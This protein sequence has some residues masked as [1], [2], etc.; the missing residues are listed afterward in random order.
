MDY[1]FS[2]GMLGGYLL[3]YDFTNTAPPQTRL[4]T[5]KWNPASVTPNSKGDHIARIDAH[6][7]H[8]FQTL[9]N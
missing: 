6:K 4:S 2:W 5:L 8:R 1:R 9:S 7:L 3:D